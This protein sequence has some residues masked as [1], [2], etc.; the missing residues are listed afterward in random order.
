MFLEKESQ[1]DATR[2]TVRKVVHEFDS[3]RLD[4]SEFYTS[5]P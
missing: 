2:G 1:N 5:L 4:L 3:F